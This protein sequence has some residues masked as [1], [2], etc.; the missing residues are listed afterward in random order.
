M[1]ARTRVKRW[2]RGR[3]YRLATPKRS[4]LLA[5]RHLRLE[6]YS[7]P[8][9]VARTLDPITGTMMV[10]I[11]RMLNRAGYSFGFPGWHPFVVALKQLLADPTLTYRQTVLA[12]YYERFQPRSVHDLLLGGLD[13]PPAALASWPAVD[14]LIDL[15]SATEGQVREFQRTTSDGHELP[16]SQYRGPTCDEFGAH[17][18]TRCL[19]VHTSLVE[20][21]YRPNPESERFVTG[22]FLTR[23]DDWRFVVGHGNHRVPAMSVLGY[24]EIPVTF[25]RSHPPVI[26]DERLHQWTTA[27]GGLLEAH[28]VRAVFDRFF[29]DDSRERAAALGLA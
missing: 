27:H 11:D 29:R 8:F 1:N 28:E 13:I 7:L 5:S 18:L 22:Y 14:R 9:E 12:S 17:H 25:R 26:A 2:L 23:D 4:G 3:G 16:H 20:H 10:P 6:R 21:G 24:T 19:D 15:W